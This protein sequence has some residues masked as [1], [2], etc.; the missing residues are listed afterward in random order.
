MQPTARWRLPSVAVNPT[1]RGKGA[2]GCAGSSRDTGV[3]AGRAHGQRALETEGLDVT[4][5]APTSPRF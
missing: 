1:G 2:A 3:A 4:Q 5:R